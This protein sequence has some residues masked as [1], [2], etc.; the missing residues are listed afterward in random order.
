MSASFDSIAHLIVVSEDSPLKGP[1]LYRA[2]EDRAHVA[3]VPGIEFGSDA[4]G[5]L[6]YAAPMDALMRGGNAW[7]RHGAIC[8][9]SKPC[10]SGAKPP[11]RRKIDNE[12]NER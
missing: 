1:F 9:T 2:P 12:T 5:R 4:H 7:S 8:V 10:R 3:V 6:S 11:E